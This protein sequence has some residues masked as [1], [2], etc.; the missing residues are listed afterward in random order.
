MAGSSR[1]RVRS[2]DAPKMTTAAGGARRWVTGVAGTNVG[3]GRSSGIAPSLQAST[4][5]MLFA[6]AD[7]PVRWKISHD[8]SAADQ[9][10][11]TI[12]PVPTTRTMPPPL[13]RLALEELAIL[14]YST[15][16]AAGPLLGLLRHGDGHPVL[17]LP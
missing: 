4:P 16:L 3:G 7:T 17:V 14:E 5:T 9:A 6:S 12:P 13:S 15:L 2:P 1:R 11:C 10:G 8:S